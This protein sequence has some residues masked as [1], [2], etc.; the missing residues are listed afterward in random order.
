MF[1]WFIS[2]CPILDLLF[3]FDTS[4]SLQN[5]VVGRNW[6]R[7]KTVFSLV[8]QQLNIGPEQVSP[9]RFPI[10]FI[11]HRFVIFGDLLQLIFPFC[12]QVRVGL[13]IFNATSREMFKL[14]EFSKAQTIQNI[15]A[16]PLWGGRTDLTQAFNFASESKLPI[17]SNIYMQTVL[18]FSSYDTVSPCKQISSFGT[19]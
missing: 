4:Q 3:L 8:L 9:F 7:L 12:V 18:T 5:N 19:L 1:V 11:K 17:H 2:D 10:H 16:S 6:E 14:G 13:V 15:T